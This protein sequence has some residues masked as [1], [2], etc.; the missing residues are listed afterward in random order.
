MLDFFSFIPSAY[1][2]GSEIATVTTGVISTKWFISIFWFFL[3]FSLLITEKIDK[4]LI[5]ILTAWLLIFFQVFTW[6]GD[7]GSSSQQIAT[8]FI[9]HNLDIFGY[10]IWMMIITW[11]VKDSWI[12]DYIWIK[13][14]KKIDGNP[15]LLFFI[16]SY[17]AFF[18]T[19]FISN[20]PTIIILAPIVVLIA[21]KLD[22]PSIPYIIWVITFANLWWAVTPISDPTTYYQSATLWFS[23]FDVISNTWLIMFILTFISSIYFYFVFKNDFALKPEIKDLREINPKDYLQSKKEIIL[24]L[25]VLV[26]VVILVV[27]KEFIFKSTWIKFDSWSISLFWAFSAILLLRYDVSSV[28]KSK[29]DYATLFFFAGI[30]IVIWA[31]EQNGIIVLLAD[32][33][34]DISWWEHWL[35]LLLFTMW[36][37]L[38]SIFIDNVPYNIAMVST[39]QSFQESWVVTWV[40]WTAL[41]WWLNSCTSIG[42]AGSPIGA[43]CNVIAIWAAEKTWVIIR[44]LKYLMIWVPLVIINSFIAFL[45]LYI[46]YIA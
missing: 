28:L 34:V 43:A 12:F 21:T 4:T 16:F 35:L 15:K 25:S 2:S 45:I 44:F 20:I 18:M 8:S 30:F 1:A 10:I 46:R 39:L 24:S 14:A 32:K 13:I 37:G 19:V 38:L 17:L 5:S 33:I 9:Y 41:A 36:S 23:F 3:L 11:I 31:L 6:A 26:W 42:W 7:G 27:L 40:T 29:V 22:L